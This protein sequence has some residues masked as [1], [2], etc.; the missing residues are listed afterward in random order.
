[1][2]PA[3]TFGNRTKLAKIMQAQKKKIKGRGN[4]IKFVQLEYLTQRAPLP[5]YLGQNHVVNLKAI[6]PEPHS[7]LLSYRRA[8]TLSLQKGR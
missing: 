5:Q 1:M 3:S 7:S 4:D 6:K 8:I 2:A